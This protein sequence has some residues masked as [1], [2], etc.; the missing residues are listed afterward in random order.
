MPLSQFTKSFLNINN[1]L[2]KDSEKLAISGHENSHTV[3]FY[4][5]NNSSVQ[6]AKTDL[7]IWK[8]PGRTAIKLSI[9]LLQNKV[10]VA[11]SIDQ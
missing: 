2:K 7:A 5:S 4:V 10:I 6:T 9:T 11:V 1:S 8:L 3:Y